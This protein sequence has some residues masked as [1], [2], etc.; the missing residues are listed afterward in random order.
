MASLKALQDQI[1]VDLSTLTNIG[2]SALGSSD[3]TG[4]NTFAIAA[5]SA[6]IPAD[7]PY[8]IQLPPPTVLTANPGLAQQISDINA[9][10]DKTQK[11][12]DN[13]LHPPILVGVVIA[14]LPKSVAQLQA[15]LQ[16][17]KQQL[18][19]L[20]A[21]L[22]VTIDLYRDAVLAFWIKKASDARCAANFLQLGCL[23]NS[24]ISGIRGLIPYH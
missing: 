22:A 7:C 6:A 18:S 16:Q 24:A 13:A 17:L 23:S 4:A 5:H 8:R 15:D 2:A 12:L 14:P 1:R 20:Q 21:Q 3:F 11:D 19:A 9:A 10:I